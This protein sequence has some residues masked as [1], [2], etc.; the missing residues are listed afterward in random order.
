MARLLIADMKETVTL[1]NSSCNE[2][3]LTL[4]LD[5][6]TNWEPLKQNSLPE[7]VHRFMITLIY[8]SSDTCFQ[9]VQN[10]QIC[11]CRDWILTSSGWGLQQQMSGHKHF[12]ICSLYIWWNK[13]MKSQLQTFLTTCSVLHH[14]LAWLCS[15]FRL[16]PRISKNDTMPCK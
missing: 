14:S 5:F 9:Q 6:S 8:V 3:P 10:I 16:I 4:H 7:C 13:T 12:M 1:I 2:G 15:R 11:N